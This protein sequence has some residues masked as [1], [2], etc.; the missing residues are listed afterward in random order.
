MYP[1]NIHSAPTLKNRRVVYICML[2]KAPAL[3]TNSNRA[4][5]VLR[6]IDASGSIKITGSGGMF[7]D[8]APRHK[9]SQSSNRE[10]HK[11]HCTSRRTLIFLCISIFSRN[12][13]TALRCG[14]PWPWVTRWRR[15]RACYHLKHSNHLNLITLKAP[16]RTW[17]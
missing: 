6:R 2:I 4:P 15:R 1:I 13:Q 17:R 7:V 11:T 9:R 10:P 5:A 12:F 3:S 16:W 14:G 8:C